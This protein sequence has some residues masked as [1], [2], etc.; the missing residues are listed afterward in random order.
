MFVTADPVFTMKPVSKERAKELLKAE[1][2]PTD[3]P[4]VGVSVRNWKNLSS[5]TTDLAALCDKIHDKLGCEIVFIP[6][7]QPNDSVISEN[8]RKNMKS[9]SYLIKENCTP[10]ELMG[11]IGTMELV[12]SMR[13]HTLIF[14]ANRA[15]PM[16]GFVYDPK[17]EYYL[18]LFNMPK[19]GSINDY[20][21]EKAFVSIKNITE[22]RQ[23]YSDDLKVISSEM[24]KHSQDN[25][26]YLFKLLDK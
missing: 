25:V 5:F 24:K 15:V 13:L 19:G 3:K 4:I 8:V 2:I 10:Q 18:N 14:A 21:M 7:Q 22:N 11:I 6:M 12:I 17:I 1:E 16:L 20:D 26:K 23:K 9:N